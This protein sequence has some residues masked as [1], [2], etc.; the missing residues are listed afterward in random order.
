MGDIK[1]ARRWRWIDP[2]LNIHLSRARRRAD[3]SFV[4][5]IT[6]DELNRSVDVLGMA[7]AHGGFVRSHRQRRH[8]AMLLDCGVQQVLGIHGGDSWPQVSGVVGVT[9]G[10]DVKRRVGLL[11]DE[12]RAR[13]HIVDRPG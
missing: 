6:A 4:L 8:E 12:V 10:H 11:L 7:A 9:D 13:R 5:T 3:C 1:L 2:H